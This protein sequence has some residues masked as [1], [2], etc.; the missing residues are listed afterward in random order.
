PGEMA[1]P[2]AQP[3]L[4]DVAVRAPQQSTLCRALRGTAPYPERLD[5]APPEPGAFA[6]ANGLPILGPASAAERRYELANAAR[7]LGLDHPVVWIS[8]PWV[9][10]MARTF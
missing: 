8:R 10:D 4:A 7:R 6:P 2:V 3:P 9:A 5:R 1:W